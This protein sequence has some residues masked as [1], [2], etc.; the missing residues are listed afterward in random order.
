VQRS[1]AAQAVLLV[2]VVT[3]V[4]ATLVGGFAAR[5]MSRRLVAA[6]DRRGSSV[7]ALLERNKD[8]HGA[9]LRRDADAARDVLELI[10]SN[11]AEMEY[12]ALLDPKGR[13]IA[14]A[15][16]G[17]G[18]PAAR[19]AAQLRFHP[20]STPGLADSDGDVRR[21]TQAVA[22]D[23][24]EKGVWAGQDELL[25]AAGTT[26]G[27]VVL[28][29]HDRGSGI[30]RDHAA[31][32]VTVLGAALAA[33]FLIFFVRLARRLRRILDFAERLAARDLSAD[34]ADPALDEVGRV[35]GAL[36]GIRDRTREVVGELAAAADALGASSLQVHRSAQVQ[37]RRAEAQADRV[38]AVG[39]TVIELERASRITGD[40]AQGVIHGANR[41]SR[42][43]EAG[44]QAVAA[45]TAAVEALR[46]DVEETAAT[47]H[48]LSQ[49]SGRIDEI[50]RAVGDLADQSNVLALNAT[51]EAARAGAAGKTFRVVSLEMRELA[52][53][54]RQATGRIRA[55]L[56]QIAKAAAAS[57]S[58]ATAGH[59]RAGE[60]VEAARSATAAIDG[61]SA[62]L[63][64]FAEAAGRIAGHAREQAAAIQEISERMAGVRE[65]ARGAAEDSAALEDASRDILGHAERLQATVEGYQLPA[66]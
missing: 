17:G 3:A 57:R 56:S 37:R 59:A 5:R 31:L 28:G 55:L 45:S 32:I 10:V 64:T 16:T 11:D 18:D 41:S 19:V 49:Q 8:L 4:T 65:E 27:Y 33:A 54:S 61:F 25:Y 38:S 39:A 63:A 53:G 23:E 9:A 26:I 21:F 66:A 6:L 2:I 1:L 35:A 15:A 50:V 7:A 58:V 22:A 30:V 42:D 46:A 29:M 13:L 24:G 12:A 44:R 14:A 60:A 40:G 20:L 62:T 47:L 36:R 52:E 51:I 34:L 48:R 43:A